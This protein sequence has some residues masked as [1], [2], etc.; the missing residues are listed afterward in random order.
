M[1]GATDL[2]GRLSTLRTLLWGLLATSPCLFAGVVFAEPGAWSDP[3]NTSGSFS[4]TAAKEMLRPVDVAQDCQ[5]TPPTGTIDLLTAVEHALCNN[6]K[7]RQAW[8]E[9]KFKA[10]QLGSAVSAF[11]PT[12]AGTVRQSSN[13][14]SSE[15]QDT[16]QL[17][18]EQRSSFRD[19]TLELSWKLIDFGAR[20]A[21]AEYARQSLLAA[22][23]THDDT[24]QSVFAT[25]VRDYYAGVAAR[26]ALEA[27]LGTEDDARRSLQAAK[28]RVQGG[29]APIID[30]LQAQTDYAQAVFNRAKVGGES[31]VLIGVLAVDMGLPPNHPLM[32]PSLPDGI[33]LDSGLERP[34]NALIDE[35]RQLHPK[36][37]AARAQLL[38]A[39]ARISSA[40][41]LGLPSVSF[42]ARLSTSTQPVIPAVG[43]PGLAATGRDRFVGL[44]LNVPIF[45]GFART[46][47][48]S[49]ARAT[50]EGQEA[51]LRDIE[52]QVT[53]NVWTTFTTLE[54]DAENVRN[55]DVLLDSA[56]QSFVAAQQR[57][58][59]GVGSIIELLTAQTSLANA[60][61]RRVQSLLDWR[62]ARLQLAASLGQLSLL[63]L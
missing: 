25:T 22:Q 58:Q 1:R 37:L 27:A 55:T 53:L 29:I 48:V 28:A 56:R 5:L 46:Y 2:Q 9:V 8:N 32:L 47:E 35:A 50:L 24:L 49:A 40:R 16:P 26:S 60:R 43:L 21:Q 51:N 18:S 36:T 23:A 13:K 11:A 30:Q 44:Q 61:Q 33:Q 7:T 17:S 42:T 39:Q 54:T 4:R 57:Y 20:Q 3:F 41:A 6:P 63:G 10:A 31:R 34:V 59:K 62:T 38:A 19:Y 52:Q 15:V 12:V 45:E 14:T